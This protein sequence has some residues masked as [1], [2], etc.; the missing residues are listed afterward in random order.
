M[1]PKILKRSVAVLAV[2][3]FLQASYLILDGLHD[4]LGHAD[5]IVVFGSKVK[6]DGTLSNRL[7]ARLDRGYELY[8]DG[9]SRTLIVSGGLG[10]EGHSEA[11]VMAAYLKTLGVPAGDILMDEQGKNTW[12]SALSFKRMAAEKGFRSVIL[13][14]SYFHLTRAKLAFKKVGIGTI[15]STHAK[16]APEFREMYSVPREVVAFYDYLLLKCHDPH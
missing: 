15:Y 6:R 10:K 4:R 11:R 5:A 14:S 1:F 9:F 7:K 8:R 13:V 2:V 3:F 16:V 12:Q